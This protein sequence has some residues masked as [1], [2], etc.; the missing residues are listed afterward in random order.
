ME[1]TYSKGVLDAQL[2][3]N[4]D[5]VERRYVNLFPSGG[6]TFAQNKFN[7]YGI[8]YSRRINRPS[9]QDL[10]PFEFQLD[11]LTYQKGNPFLNPQ[12]THN[13][14]LT[15]TWKSMINTRLSYSITDDFFAR[16][17]ER[18]DDNPQATLFQQ[19]NLATSQNYGLNISAPFDIM[20]WWS[21]YSS[22]SLNTNVY[23]SQIKEDDID[24]TQTT[25]NLY[26]QNNFALPK[27]YRL[28]VS[29]WYNSPSIW[30]GTFLMNEM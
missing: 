1:D 16:V 12:Y 5:I 8:N 30:G 7:Q 26:M 19:Q 9:Y 3:S 11:E 23:E 20:K 4:D 10:N 17:I 29:G 6:F 28:E 24:L 22:I 2:D 14:Q 27:G 13:F 15:H 18:A 21:T 25:F